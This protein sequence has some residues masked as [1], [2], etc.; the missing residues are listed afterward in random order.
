MKTDYLYFGVIVVLISMLIG[1]N[2]QISNLHDQI[3]QQ[4]VQ[5]NVREI[6]ILTV[7]QVLTDRQNDIKADFERADDERLRLLGLWNR[8]RPRVQAKAL[9]EILEEQ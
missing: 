5:S 2:I 8:I 7:M 6:E 1:S 3:T 9:D 4:R